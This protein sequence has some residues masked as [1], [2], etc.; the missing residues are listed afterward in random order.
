MLQFL[1]LLGIVIHSAKAN[2]PYFCSGTVTSNSV[3]YNSDEVTS[4]VRFR[5][6]GARDGD[7][8]ALKAQHG[9]KL[10]N[11]G[12]CAN[13]DYDFVSHCEI[14][15]SSTSYNYDD[16]TPQSTSK[17]FCFDNVNTKPDCLN[18]CAATWNDADETF[19][20]KTVQ[21]RD[22]NPSESCC[23]SS[24]GAFSSSFETDYDSDS[25]HW[26]FYASPSACFDEPPV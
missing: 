9:R 5:L 11:I 14:I 15:I 10:D 22:N 26:C 12:S 3:T 16:N 24:T 19:K 8:R 17:T 25:H 2:F 23:Y 7:R 13:S 21:Y 18:L 6:V 20:C 1:L 4:G